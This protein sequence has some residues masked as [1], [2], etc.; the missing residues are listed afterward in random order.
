MF[1][2]DVSSLDDAW[3]KVSLWDAA[4]E[5]AVDMIG[6]KKLRMA[7]NATLQMF[8]YI[9]KVGLENVTADGLLLSAGMGLLEP[10]LGDAVSKYGIDGI[11]KG[12]KKIGI[13]SKTIYD[14]TRQL[15]CFTAGTESW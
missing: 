14:L 15:A 12:L 9:D 3:S 2:E 1:D 5:S 4:T 13:D 11:V 8:N 6:T 7:A 10:I